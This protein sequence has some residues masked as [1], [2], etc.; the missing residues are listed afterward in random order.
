MKKILIGLF[1]LLV[2]IPIIVWG[3]L[4]FNIFV[5]LI[6]FLGLHEFMS[7]KD[8][9]KEIPIFIK[10]ICY[11]SLSFLIFCNMYG[12]SLILTIDYR[13]LGS[14]FMLLLIPNVL[15]HDKSLY[16][17]NDAFYLMGGVLF[18]GISFSLLIL[19]RNISLSMFIYL[20]LIG[21]VSDT[22]AFIT[23]KLIGKHYL[24]KDISPNKTIEGILGGLLVGTFIPCLYY[25][26][27]I[28]NISLM[29]IIFITL[30]LSLLGQIGDLCFSSIKRYFDVKDFSNLIPC[31]GGIL[32][33]FD[34]IIFIFLGFMFFINVI[35]G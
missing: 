11:I 5:F 14:I 8:K 21:I 26:T 19:V 31:H 18:L 7:I 20:I 17:I 30:F 28:G 16:S 15:Y 10:L 34:S 1:L 25:V 3:G 22:Y 9:K 32:D 24:L 29:S 13:I 2:S 4:I 27:V 33:R 6:S 23:G 12:S 35:G